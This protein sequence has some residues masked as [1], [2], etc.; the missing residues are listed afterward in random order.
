MKRTCH[1]CLLAAAALLTVVAQAQTTSLSFSEVGVYGTHFDF[2][3]YSV[4]KIIYM[5]ERAKPERLPPFAEKLRTTRA[6]GRKNLVGLYTFD[7]VKHAMPVAEALANTDAVLAALDLADVHALFLSEENVTWGK[8]L[9]VLNAL[10][11]HIKTRYPRLPVYQW[12]TSPAGPHAKL[13]ADGWVY[14][15]YNAGREPFRR[16]MTEYL[17]TGKPFIMCLNAS[18][19]VSLFHEPNGGA[20]SQEQLDVCREFAIPTFYYCVDLKWGSPAIWLH[21]NAPEIV[22]WREWLLGAVDEIHHTDTSRLPQL[23]AQYTDGHPIE[24]AGDVQN[25]FEFTERFDSVRFVSDAT[26]RG[27]LNWRWDGGR[28]QLVAERRAGDG[29]FAQ[30]Y[31]HFTS[32]FHMSRISAVLSGRLLSHTVPPPVLAL[33]VTGH[34]WPHA[35]VAAPDGTL[36]SD[37]ELRLSAE[38]DTDFL[39]Q[40]LWVRVT[41]PV[42]E[43][44]QP[45]LAIDTLKVTCTVEPPERR[46]ISLEPS[47]KGAVHYRDTFDS[48]KYLHLAHIENAEQLTWDR[49]LIG[50]HGVAGRGNRVGLKWKLVCEKPLSEIRVAVT[51]TANRKNLGSHNTVAVSLDGET[52]LAEDTTADKPANSQGTYQGTLTLDLTAE[53]RCQGVSELWVHV[54]MTNNSGAKTRR[55]NTI[56]TLE[57]WAKAAR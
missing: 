10:Y 19:D 23:S 51:G 36:P 6:A 11:D 48:Q 52:K 14:D 29:E 42:G 43:L 53:S 31:Y 45:I 15:Y 49:G 7:R 5:G 27:F 34:N 56:E 54:D 30:L 37:T 35:A 47:R 25:H 17:V 18:P 41:C 16:K 28:E 1:L 13:R 55:S 2:C 3:D 22:P 4:Y 40:D 38:D 26:L 39:G 8:G 24:A 9:E 57:V 12:L 32:D 21:S 33:S 20:V 50:T 44:R 46:E